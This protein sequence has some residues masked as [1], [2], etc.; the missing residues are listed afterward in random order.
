VLVLLTVALNAHGAIE[1][2]PAEVSFV[3]ADRGTVYADFYGHAARRSRLLVLMFHQAG[4]NAA[5]Y[6][7]IAPRILGFGFDCL[8]VDTRSGGFKFLRNNRTVMARG[9]SAGFDEVYADMEAAL[10]WAT[11]NKGYDG[12]VAWGSSYTAALV[13]RLAAEHRE[14][15]AVISFSPGEHLGEGEPVRA[16]ASR[17]TVPI[18]VTSAPGVEVGEAAR[19]VDSAVSAHVSQ[20]VPSAGV[21]GSSALRDD[22]NPQSSA[23]YWRSLEAFVRS[24]L[25]AASGSGQDNPVLAPET[26]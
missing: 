15:R 2:E 1:L 22:V 21:H 3:T 20:F 19:I 16:Y 24:E 11:Q 12:V 23:D 10:R 17:V 13:F 14:V 7:P 5:E 8:A 25:V 9:G 4:S 6:A 26:P 18:F